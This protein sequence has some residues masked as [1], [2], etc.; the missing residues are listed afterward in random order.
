MARF[1]HSIVTPTLL[2]VRVE[3]FTLETYLT[4]SNFGMVSN[5][6]SS[7]FFRQLPSVNI[8]ETTSV[9][10]GNG[11]CRISELRIKNPT[12]LVCDHCSLLL[13]TLISMPLF[14]P[15]PF[16]SETTMVSTCPPPTDVGNSSTLWTSTQVNAT[17]YIC[18]SFAWTA[19]NTGNFT[20]NMIL[21][22]DPDYWYVDDVSILAGATEKL[23]NGGFETNSLYPWVQTFPSGSYAGAPAE[24]MNLPGVARTG[25]Y[26]L[27]DGSN[28]YADQ[29]A[30]S[31]SAVS[32]QTYVIS[33]WLKSTANSSTGIYANFSIV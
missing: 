8:S 27:R 31:F 15:S 20:F 24:V 33:F 9:T 7:F 26:G 12:S 23:V 2:R 3:M 29:V 22:N 18:H 13:L 5:A 1:S 32:G 16:I 19:T 17:G 10:A 14:I 4:S 6:S 21:R 11:V 25:T 30:Q 28:T